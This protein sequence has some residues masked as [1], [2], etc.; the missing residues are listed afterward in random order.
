MKITMKS[1]A[2]LSLLPWLALIAMAG[3]DRTDDPKAPTQFQSDFIKSC[4]TSIQNPSFSW[5]PPRYADGVCRCAAPKIETQLHQSGFDKDDQHSATELANVSRIM[6]ASTIDCAKPVFVQVMTDQS[7]Q[8]CLSADNAD[9]R[10]K[11]LNTEA[12]EQAC[13]CAAGV[14]GKNADL[15]LAL[16]A[17]KRAEFER[18]GKEQFSQALTQCGIK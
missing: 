17:E 14:Y 6:T 11:A 1:A 16:Q 5:M 4:V 7:K 18:Q 2:W 13:T 3:C 12:R 9:P 15:G 8:Q 10:L